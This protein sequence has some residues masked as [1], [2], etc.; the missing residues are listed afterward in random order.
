MNDVVTH[1]FKLDELTLKGTSVAGVGTSFIIPELKI[2]FDVAQG[3]PF[4]FTMNDYFIT[5]GHMDH[6]GGIPYVISQKALMGL[7][8]G[9]FHMP[10]P[11]LTPMKT[12]LS[13]WS[14]LEGHQYEYEFRGVE[15][16]TNFNIAKNWD[17]ETFPTLHRVPSTG[18][19]LMRKRKKLK[20]S[21]AGLSEAE[22]VQLRRKG[23]A[24]EEEVR[25]PYLSFT[26]DT[27]TEFLDLSPEVKKSRF[28]ILEVT[29]WND[30][31]S[32]SSAR[33][34]GHIHFYEFVKRLDEL[35]CEKVVLMHLSA[36]HSKA[37]VD[38]E[39]KRKLSPEQRERLLIFPYEC[40]V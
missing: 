22:I 17:V 32:V 5:H 7:K 6:A 20:A 30:K 18:Y 27:Q 38:Y 21:L 25:E 40:G 13:T 16:R 1:V 33:E 12:I 10:E 4:A 26:G 15:G 3:L 9:H 11:M 19:T 24:V 37:E 31:K 36:R 34:W 8:P 23:E 14:Q 2:A 39:L 29:Y 28:L 35:E